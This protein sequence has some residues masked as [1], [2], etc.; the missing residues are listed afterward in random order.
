MMRR[1]GYTTDAKGYTTQDGS[2]SVLDALTGTVL[3]TVPLLGNAG[4]V[5]V[6]ERAGRAFV[7]TH[8]RRLVRSADPWGWIPSPPRRLLPFV[9]APPAPG[10][11]DPVSV[12][13]IDATR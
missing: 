1:E 8:G 12:T 10:V 7:V 5:V 4:P 3:R 6:D 2:F 9:P 13:M 11:A